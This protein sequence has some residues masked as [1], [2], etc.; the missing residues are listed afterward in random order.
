[1]KQKHVRVHII[2]VNKHFN[3][4]FMITNYCFVMY[5]TW[6][7]VVLVKSF[8]TVVYT[9][10]TEVGEPERLIKVSIGK[11]GLQCLSGVEE[12]RPAK[13]KLWIALMGRFSKLN[14][15]LLI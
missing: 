3:A 12:T 8:E 1:M 9:P 10:K 5:S 13:V 2:M 15:T 11:T 14:K 4:Y 6:N 7:I